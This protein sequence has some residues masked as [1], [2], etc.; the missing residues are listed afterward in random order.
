[1]ENK[2]AAILTGDW[3]YRDDVPLCRIDD[4]L[5]V[6]D[7]KIN[8]ITSLA[9]K[10]NVPILHS[11]DLFNK[12]YSNKAL[13][14]S[15]IEKLRDITIY[16]IPGNHD[17]VGHSFDN[18]NDSSIGVVAAAL[19]QDQ[20]CLLFAQPY[21]QFYYS[22]LVS[23]EGKKI[24][25]IHEFVDNPAYCNS[26]IEGYSARKML[27]ICSE[28]DLVLTGD[29]HQTFIYPSNGCLLVNPGS[30]MRMN[31]EQINHR[32]CI[33]LWYAEDNRVEQVFLPIEKNVIDTSHIDNEK[34]KDER[35]S[36]FIKRMNTKYELSLSF[37]KNMEEH[38][39]IN[40]V[41]PS[42][43]KIIWRCIDDK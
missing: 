36:A 27:D 42:V 20:D 6:Q 9:K 16:F 5:K 1:M 10:Y 19:E 17:L 2:P 3:H 26:N 24:I 22:G 4:Y 15:L 21:K 12:A 32:P 39:K 29:N 40:K 8:F 43:E 33:F 34:E 11:G 23:C 41:K 35:T 7:N 37:Q 25:I 30:I 38:L 18:L 28:A 31:V 13:E 14:I